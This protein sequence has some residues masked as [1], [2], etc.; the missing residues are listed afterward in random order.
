MALWYITDNRDGEAW[1]WNGK[2]FRPIQ[3]HAAKGYRSEAA[4]WKQAQKLYAKS[5]AIGFIEVRQ[6]A[7]LQNV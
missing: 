5:L 7:S 1:T 4:A 6:A 3:R 2:E